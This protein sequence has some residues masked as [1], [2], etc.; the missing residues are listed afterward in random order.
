[1]LVH[2]VEPF[3]A[4]PTS[5]ALVEHLLTPLDCFY[6]RNHGAIPV[7]EEARWRLAVDGL[8]DHALNLSLADL[9]RRFEHHSVTATLQCAG[10]R[11]AELATVRDIPNEALWRDGA[12][13]TAEWTGVRLAD[14]LAAAGAR[15]DAG[16]VR[17][18]A[19]DVSDLADPPQPYGGSIELA[20]AVRPEVLLA[21]A[22]N[23]EPLPAAHGAPVRVVAP[24]YIGARSVKWLQRITVSEQ[25]SDNYFQATAYRLLPPEADPSQAGPEDGLSLGPVALN[26][27]ILSPVHGDTVTAGA[28]SV[29]GYAFAGDGRTVCRVDV[30]IDGGASWCQADLGVDAG[31]WAWRMWRLD[32]ELAPGDVHIVARAWDSSAALQPDDAA[33]VWNPKGYVNNSRPHAQ[34]RVTPDPHG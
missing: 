18:E 33:D 11:R 14:V 29:R 16:H 1:M 25:A 3:N 26:S 22:M 23:G 10:N 20:K 8:V 5:A 32:V 24:G 6:S 13:S 12:T 27:A 15:A 7:L 28:T 2:E 34:V 31:R 30:S 19:P 17:F 21:W 9:Q 4:E